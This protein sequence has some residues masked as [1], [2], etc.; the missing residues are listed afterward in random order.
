MKIN[1]RM[2]FAVAMTCHTV[3][4]CDA[5]PPGSGKIDRQAIVSRNDIIY[6]Q[7]ELKAPVSVGNGK[8]AFTVDATGL[9]TFP[10]AYD[11][12][13]VLGTMADYGWHSN[14][15]PD[16][17]K[18]E[19][20]YKEFDSHGRKQLYPFSAEGAKRDA[21]KPA[22][23]LFVNPH[24]MG[25]GRIGLAL[26]KADGTAP[27]LADLK[28]I[29]QHLD[30]WTGGLTSS[31]EIEGQPVKVTTI[32][33][34]VHDQIAIRI[35]SPLVK[36]N[37][38]RVR[39][40][41]PYANT[42]WNLGPEDWEHP[43]KH[44]TEI[45][46]QSNTRVDFSRKLDDKDSSLDDY[47]CAVTFPAGAVLQK[48]S[49]HQ[50][51][52][53]PGSGSA[54]FEC[55]VAFAEK[56]VPK[57]LPN[58]AGTQTAAADYWKNYWS[59]GGF[60]DL[61]ASKDPRWRELERRI[62]LSQY[63]LA[64]NNAGPLPPQECGLVQKSWLGKFHMEMV[65][66]H[67]A[68][69]ALWGRLPLMMRCMGIYEQL[70]PSSRERARLQECQGARWPKMIGP[71]GRES[72]G[73]I[74]PFLVWQQPHPIYF[75]E[76]DYRQNPTK[77]TLQRWWEI[78]KATA[79][80]M[81]TFA[82]KDQGSDIYD[83]GP[84]LNDVHER[85][86]IGGTKNAPFEVAYFRYGLDLARQWRA[87]MGLKPDPL[88]DDVAAHLAPAPV[89]AGRYEAPIVQFALLPLTPDLDR[90]VLDQ[91]VDYRVKHLPKE[92][93]SWGYFVTAMAAARA[94]RA[95]LAVDALLFPSPCTSVSR[96]GYNYWNQKVPV[97][98][99][100][101]GALLSAVAM[102]AGGWDGAPKRNAPG[103]PDDGQ[104][105]IKSEGLQPLP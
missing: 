92:S 53:Q 68:H 76:L 99:P 71:E 45:I 87:R 30:L 7:P 97:Y 80:F 74:N 73:S 6:T 15:N 72:P 13:Y 58:F 90:S 65:W 67:E 100:G 63:V 37:R 57:A 86:E 102:M 26:T 105:V 98:L 94:G 70:L 85:S 48:E 20:A 69:F 66:F 32:V 27:V 16:G 60:V 2:L 101:N 75:A 1:V 41:F 49:V 77:A 61:S 25:L 18:I 38:L 54:V 34:P 52:V 91:T 89:K 22:K 79:D 5:A 14:P 104:W 12:G 31:F 82:V 56:S 10:E 43:E 93:C 64:V 8:F 21:N 23:W 17:Y 39:I 95:D 96:A 55:A 44:T 47:R 78:V 4:L 28:N 46:A 42:T 40:A 9:Q 81:A 19:D 84:P 50:Y 62:I 3:L 59:N 11:Q 83:V 36:S 29:K 103:F 51:L 88:W 24:R 35:E 33:H